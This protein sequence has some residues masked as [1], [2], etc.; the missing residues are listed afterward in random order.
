MGRL[1]NKLGRPETSQVARGCTVPK[2]GGGGTFLFTRVPVKRKVVNSG[3]LIGQVIQRSGRNRPFPLEGVAVG[4][5]CLQ[6]REMCKKKNAN[7]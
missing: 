2:E 1:E 6:V 4:G 5:P 7:Y 3:K